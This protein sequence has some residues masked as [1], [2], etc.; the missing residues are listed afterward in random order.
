MEIVD[1][2]QRSQN[3]YDREIS[4][5]GKITIGDIFET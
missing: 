4:I 1:N 5:Q 2:N 3:V